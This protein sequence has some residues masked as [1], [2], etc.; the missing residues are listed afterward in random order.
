MAKGGSAAAFL[1]LLTR[2]YDL[3]APGHWRMKTV[4]LKFLA[5]AAGACLEALWTLKEKRE[6]LARFVSFLILALFVPFLYLHLIDQPPKLGGL[7]LHKVDLV[8]TYFVSYIS[9]G[10]CVGVVI[11]LLFERYGPKS[12]SEK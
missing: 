3:P 2:L 12:K 9:F 11:S 4:A 5:C 8:F 10:F 1:F 7:K 6:Q